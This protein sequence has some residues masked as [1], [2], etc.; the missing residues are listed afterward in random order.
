[1]G[2]D[3]KVVKFPNPKGRKIG[4]VLT[5][6]FIIIF[7]IIIGFSSIKNTEKIY[8]AEYGYLKPSAEGYGILVRREQVIKAPIPGSIYFLVQ[9]NARVREGD[10]IVE[11]I[12]S[13]LDI[14]N[15]NKRLE[16]IDQAIKKL[17]GIYK[18]RQPIEEFKT[19][20]TGQKIEQKKEQIIDA[21]NNGDLSV[22]IALKKEILTYLDKKENIRKDFN[23]PITDLNKERQALIEQT[24]KAS[25]K[26]KAPFSGVVSYKIDNFEE[27]F[28]LE[29]LEELVQVDIKNSNYGII[30][31][32]ISQTKVDEP[33]FKVVDNFKW[34]MVAETDAPF[35][36]FNNTKAESIWIKFSSGERVKCEIIEVLN[37]GRII[38]SGSE[39]FE[40]LI[41]ERKIPIKVEKDSEFGVI[42]PVA[43]IISNDNKQGVMIKGLGGK[44][45]REI[46]I[47]CKNGNQAVVTGVKRWE[48]IVN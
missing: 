21:V 40:G 13:S 47:L 4:R 7:G 41:S 6:G 25:I 42:I 39:H 33:V 43:A 18:S 34:Y 38:I 19:T 5:A 31:Y 23:E 36:F 8:T 29:N 44:E 16:E 37:N 1:M 2:K 24:E 30:N 14:E 27:I 15:I 10:V 11:I 32:K 3:K 22:L 20:E 12:N 26:L 45:F 9:E 48:K 28:N 17:E 46:E 35:D